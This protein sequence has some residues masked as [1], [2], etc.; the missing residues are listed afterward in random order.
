MPQGLLGDAL[1]CPS[2][3]G[4][5][6]AGSVFSSEGKGQLASGGLG[7]APSLPQASGTFFSSCWLKEGRP[8]AL[9]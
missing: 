2:G 7:V 5:G 8:S 1:D 6:A 9:A 3:L 4:W